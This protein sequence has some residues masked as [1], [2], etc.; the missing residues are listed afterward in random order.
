MIYDLFFP[1]AGKA[2]V[3]ALLALSPGFEPIS[4]SSS[5]FGVGKSH[6]K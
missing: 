2:D 5:P 4:R 1:D 6:L 3:F